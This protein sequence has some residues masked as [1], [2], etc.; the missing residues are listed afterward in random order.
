[1]SN[2]ALSSSLSRREL[3]VRSLRGLGALGLGLGAGGAGLVSMGCTPRH[4]FRGS[5]QA[6]DAN[7]LR[8]LPGFRSR[9][10]ARTGE[11]VASTGHVWHAA[12]DGGAVFPTDDGGWVYVSN[13]EL[14]RGAGGVGAIRFA[15]DGAIVDAYWILQGTTRNCAGGP[16]PW[17]TWLSCEETDRG[18]V[19][20]CDPYTPGS[21]GI[22][23]PAMG[24]F[25]HEAA[26]VDPLH[27]CVYMT[28]DRPSGLLYRFTP[29]RYPSLES[30]RL[31]AAE[32]LDP[33]GS[34]PIAPGEV[35]RLAWHVVPDPSASSEDTRSQVP[36]ATPFDGGEGCWF[37]QGEVCLSTKG[38]DRIWLFD[39]RSNQIRILYDRATSPFPILSGVDNLFMSERGDV[40]VAEDPGDL[41]IVVLTRS[42]RPQAIVQAHEQVG[43]EIA[44]LAL[45]PDG[46][47]LY[48]SSQRLPGT[49]Y[50]VS[51]PF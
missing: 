23:R 13:A 6:A 28:E 26:A 49:T 25:Q 41:Q 27:R 42:G 30:G 46:T 8:L 32:I 50:E 16:T 37:H 10:V 44:G 33:E 5:L 45:S 19:Y 18:Q 17:K 22:V 9:V 12:P 20:E 35:R 31:E 51:G 2:R 11:E 4:R 15:A 47:R 3:L 38:D 21:Q 34:G 43:S 40:Y 7:G 39:T 24:I 48:L 36:S 1:M 14:E 29:T